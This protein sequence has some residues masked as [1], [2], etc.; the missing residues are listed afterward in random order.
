MSF[1]ST[2]ALALLLVGTQ[3]FAATY[4]CSSVKP[5]NY[6][7]VII[8]TTKSSVTVTTEESKLYFL[9]VSTP[10]DSVETVFSGWTANGLVTISVPTYVLENTTKDLFEM[11]YSEQVMPDDSQRFTNAYNCTKKYF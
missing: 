5:L 1:K 4:Y 10:N 8:E 2:L 7:E 3:S 9:K 11:N 6:S